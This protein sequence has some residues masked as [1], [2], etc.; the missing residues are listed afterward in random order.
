MGPLLLNGAQPG[1]EFRTSSHGRSGG[2]LSGQVGVGLIDV[3]D[4]LP[5]GAG[6]L[7]RP[8]AASFHEA[9]VRQAQE[10]FPHRHGADRQHLRQAVL[11]HHLAGWKLSH[12]DHL[13]DGLGHLLAERLAPY[14]ER[15]VQAGEHCLVGHLSTRS[16]RG[17]RRRR[18]RPA[19]RSGPARPRQGRGG[20]GCRLQV[21]QPLDDQTRL[22]LHSFPVWPCAPSTSVVVRYEILYRKGWPMTTPERI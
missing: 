16:R 4:V 9:F 13:P 18:L 15:R 5:A 22:G 8:V 20:P 7:E 10:R 19:C 6:D 12:E 3:I 21:V 2:E 14:G 17:E 1:G 11:G